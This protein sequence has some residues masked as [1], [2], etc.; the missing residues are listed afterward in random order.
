MH[1]ESFIV[2]FVKAQIDAESFIIHRPHSATTGAAAFSADGELQG[3]II[4]MY[5]AQ[6]G[7]CASLGTRSA[8][9]AFVLVSAIP[10]QLS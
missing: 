10:L 4:R 7:I 9:P 5:S 8:V 6:V 2:G 3:H 1:A